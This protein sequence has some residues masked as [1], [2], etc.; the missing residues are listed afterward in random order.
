MQ[1]NS[2]SSS[3]LISIRD[4]R[5]IAGLSESAVYRGVAAKSFPPPVKLGPKMSRWFRHEV[6]EWF[7]DRVAEREV[8]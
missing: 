1:D 7:N 4:V 5:K 3:D 6:Q 2:K 8:A